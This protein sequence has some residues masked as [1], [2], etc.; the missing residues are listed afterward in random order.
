MASLFLSED[1]PHRCDPPM[2]LV[3]AVF[4]VVSIPPL[5]PGGLLKLVAFSLLVLGNWILCN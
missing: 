3:L 5:G 4:S 1:E 2:A